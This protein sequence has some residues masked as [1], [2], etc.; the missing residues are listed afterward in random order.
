MLVKTSLI[1]LEFFGT[2]LQTY[3]KYKATC[4]C[5][6]DT[7]REAFSIHSPNDIQSPSVIPQIYSS[8]SSSVG[9]HRRLHNQFPPFFSLFSTALRDLADTRPVHSL[10]MSSHLFNFLCVCLPS[11]VFAGSPSHGGDVTL[12]I[13]HKPTELAHSFL[14]RLLVWIFLSL[15]PFVAL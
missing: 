14:F 3:N 2:R 15:L 11:F 4:I 12:Y 7:K 8:P 1:S 10:M 5:F 9:H 6:I 13:S